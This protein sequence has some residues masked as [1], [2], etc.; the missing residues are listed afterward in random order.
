MRVKNAKNKKKLERDK[1][2]AATT[3]QKRKGEDN[4]N[5]THKFLLQHCW[6][7]CCYKPSSVSQQVA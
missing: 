5:I 6:M 4:A 1:P 7:I 2:T 3:A